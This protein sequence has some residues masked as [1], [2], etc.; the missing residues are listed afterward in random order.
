MRHVQTRFRA[1]LAAS[2]ATLALA[3]TAEAQCPDAFPL[4]NY[5]AGQQQACP[6]FV[7]GEQAGATFQAPESHY[8]IEITRVRITYG[9]V[10]GGSGQSLEEAI[11]LYEGGLPNPGAPIF[12]LPAPVLT[13]GF[14]N[15]FDISII[16]GSKVIQSGPFTVALEYFSQSAG[17]AFA[18]AVVLDS[19]GCQ[20]GKNPTFVIPGGWTDGCA[21]GISGDWEIQVVYRRALCASPGSISLSAGGAQS[22]V[23]SAGSDRAGEIYWI[24]G[25]ATGT[26]PGLTGSGVTLP[27]NYDVYMQ[28]TLDLPNLWIANSLNF[29]DAQGQ[30]TA[31]LTFPAAFDP[32]LA[33]LQL[34]HAYVVLDTAPITPIFASNAQPL[35]LVP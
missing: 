9:S 18:P 12:S 21:L 30:S 5:S 10:F 7:P 16:P 17:S 11:H 2:L 15:E 27:L 23:L 1:P 24:V 33:G 28:F 35:T 26:S 34:H 4:Q 20:A 22:Y 29:L 25:S 32:T 31:S 19:N 8:P 14:V 13:D 6:C 3:G